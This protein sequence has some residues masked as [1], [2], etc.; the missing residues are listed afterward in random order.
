MR[1]YWNRHGLFA[2]REDGLSDAGR[3]PH[4][5]LYGDLEIRAYASRYRARRAIIAGTVQACEDLWQRADDV[6]GFCHSRSDGPALALTEVE[7]LD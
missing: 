3:I 5:G 2:R 1:G 7:L 4:I 6:S